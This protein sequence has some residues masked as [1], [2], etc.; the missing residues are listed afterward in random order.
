MQSRTFSI[1][2]HYHDAQSRPVGLVPYGR[3]NRK[4]VESPEA[5]PLRLA[6]PTSGLF[7]QDCIRRLPNS[8]AIR[9]PGMAAAVRVPL[10]RLAGEAHGHL[11]APIAMHAHTMP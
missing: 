3:L 1:T 10:R 4:S 9:T 5:V 6:P 7:I 2:P 11:A 8:F